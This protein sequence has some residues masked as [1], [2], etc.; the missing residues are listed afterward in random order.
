MAYPGGS[1]GQQNNFIITIRNMLVWSAKGGVAHAF[2]R[3][4][5]S[6][7]LPTILE[8]PLGLAVFILHF[9]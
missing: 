7:S 8:T 9:I 6:T 2:V 1:W 5:L 4:T 3:E